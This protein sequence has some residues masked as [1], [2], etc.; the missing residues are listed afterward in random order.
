V[1][2]RGRRRRSGGA[3]AVEFAAVIL[4]LL[5]F[6]LG[7]VDLASMFSAWSTLQWACDGA[8]RQ[9]EVTTSPTVTTAETAAQTLANSVG[10]TSSTGIS[11]SQSS[12]V[13]CGNLNCIKIVG[14][15][16]FHFNLTSLGLGTVNLSAQALAPLT[17]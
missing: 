7:A 10:Y 12:Q 13:T 2:T 15:Y 3:T 9:T 5:A 16:T 17:P 14:T 8:A 6:C 4:P 1:N 11:F